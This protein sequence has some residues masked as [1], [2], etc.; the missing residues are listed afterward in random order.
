MTKVGGYCESKKTEG[1]M[2]SL[3]SYVK[4]S[5]KF[6]DFKSCEFEVYS[7]GSWA[8]QHMQIK[9]FASHI[10]STNGDGFWDWMLLETKNISQL[11]LVILTNKFEEFFRWFQRKTSE[12]GF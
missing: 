10:M 6:F 9:S 4:C 3:R 7:Q 1:V 2:F 5:G 8:P 11:N 12:I